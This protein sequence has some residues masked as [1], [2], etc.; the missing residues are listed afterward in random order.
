M[1]TKFRTY[2]RNKIA[3][4]TTLIEEGESWENQGKYILRSSFE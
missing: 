1:V 3:K 4:G 2:G